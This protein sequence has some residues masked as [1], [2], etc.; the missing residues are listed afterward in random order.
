MDGEVWISVR[1]E[2][3][4]FDSSAVSDP[5]TPESRLVDHG[6]G[7]YLMRALMDEVSFEESGVVVYMRKKSNI[8]GAERRAA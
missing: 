1:D 6:R 5:T 3:P 7:I 8:P 2:G 4:G